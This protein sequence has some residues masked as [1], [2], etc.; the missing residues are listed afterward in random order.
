[1]KNFQILSLLVLFSIFTSC[2]TQEDIRRD[3][4]VDNLNEQVAQTQKSTATASSR[5][6]ALEEEIEKITGK[7]EESLHHKQQEAK[8][9]VNLKERLSFLEENNKKQT[10]LI[11]SLN[12]KMQNQTKYLE[13][14]IASINTLNEQREHNQ[15]LEE[16]RQKE[17]EESH[18]A[19]AITVKAA[20]AKYKAS[21][22]ETSKEMFLNIIENKK[23]K[24]KD[25]ETSYYYLGMIEYKGKNYEEAKVY[26]SKLFSENP[27][28]SFAASALLNLAKSFLQLK[29]NDEAKQSLDELLSR[30]PKSKEAHEGSKLKIKI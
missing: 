27:D 14:V 20:V 24:K 4:T 11:K 17:K 16:K 19:K 8:D 3:K 2:K 23:G 7:I 1:M 15:K 26:F 25:K 13:E 30:Y 28:S 21:E 6:M 22:L 12:D 18:P 29:S 10:E 5:F 9:V